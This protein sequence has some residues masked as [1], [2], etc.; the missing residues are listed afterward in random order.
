MFRYVVATHHET[1]E[2]FFNLKHLAALKSLS[3]AIDYSMRVIDQKPKALSLQGRE[4]LIFMDYIFDTEKI[5]RLRK[6]NKPYETKG[7][8]VR[9]PQKWWR[10]ELSG[11]KPI[12]RCL[13]IS[14]MVWGEIK[15]STRKLAKELNIKWET[16]QKWLK[17]LRQ[18]NF[19]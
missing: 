7:Y 3:K 18:K 11:L 4:F 12:E 10:K 9:I 15:P 14:L 16:A 1:K 8:W 17:R 5:K 19:I 13:L 6:I 2:L